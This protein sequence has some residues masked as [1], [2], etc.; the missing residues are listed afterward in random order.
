MQL[1]LLYN[2]ATPTCKTKKKKKY[3][4]FTWITSDGN[5]YVCT[6]CII[7]VRFSS[8]FHGA[9]STCIIRVDSIEII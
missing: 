6:Y 3:N 4:K 9:F 8:S 5:M 1:Q 2:I 7:G